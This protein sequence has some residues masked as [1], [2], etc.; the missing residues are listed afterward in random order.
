MRQ[1]YAE[2][3]FRLVSQSVADLA[4]KAIGNAP[5]DPATPLQ[6][7]IREEPKTR[8]PSANARMWAGTL[9]DLANQAW[10]GG[11]QYPAEVW[12]EHCKA[13]YLPEDD[14][15]DLAK[16]VK[17]PA[18]WRKWDHTPAG[19]RVCIGSTTHL[20]SYGI[21]QYIMQIEA[22]GADL[23]VRFSAVER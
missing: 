1:P 13:Q 18:V 12:H 21:S 11:R 5:I 10:I 20:T 19:M 2:R 22:M 4:C 9:S 6:V 23:G 3:T 14:D 17:D 15:P 8:R 16:L 7:V